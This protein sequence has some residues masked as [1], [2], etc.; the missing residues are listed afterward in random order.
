M[1]V[2]E[3]ISGLCMVDIENKVNMKWI[4]ISGSNIGKD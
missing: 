1:T 2:L 4:D 3:E